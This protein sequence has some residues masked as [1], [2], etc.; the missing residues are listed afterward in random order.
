MSTKLTSYVWDVCATSGM[1]GTK[2]L[3]LLRLA[4]FSNDEGVS[5]PSIDTIVSQTGSS[6]SAVKLALSS[7]KKDDWLYVKARRNG[8]RN[9][10]NLYCINV[11]K[12]QKLA[13]EIVNSHQPNSD[14]SHSDRS[15]TDPTEIDLSENQIPNI[16]NASSGYGNSQGSNPDRTES[17]PD[18]YINN[19]INN[20]KLGSGNF[21]QISDADKLSQFLEKHPQAEIYSANGKY[22]GSKDDLKVAQYIYQKV[23]EINPT[24]QEPNWPRWSN[25]IRLLKK[26]V[27]KRTREILEVFNWANHHEFWF[28][29]ILSPSSL[30]EKWMILTTQMLSDSKTVVNKSSEI[31]WNS[32]GWLREEVLQ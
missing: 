3:V 12:L 20:N 23:L 25:E 7:L 5:F 31:D 11:Q 24:Y 26:R 14:P 27:N 1:K 18:P 30:S 16:I 21:S 17:D 15:K 13:L 28:K 6:K 29:N 10:S 22:W 8:Q 32:T 9:D 19:N 2:L 4:D